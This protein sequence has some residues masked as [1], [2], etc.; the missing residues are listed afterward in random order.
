[1]INQGRKMLD[2]PLDA[3]Y[4]RADARTVVVEPLSMPADYSGV[5]GVRDARRA[6]RN[7]HYELDLE[8]GADPAEVIRHIVAGPPVRRVELKRATLEDIFIDV[9]KG[10]GAPAASEQALRDSLRA[11]TPQTAAGAGVSRA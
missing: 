8:D 2:A 4:A 3:I 1:M 9:V 5:P 7:G 6:D 10:K 11:S